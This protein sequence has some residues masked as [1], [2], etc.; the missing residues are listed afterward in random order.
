MNK[1]HRAMHPMY[2][3]IITKAA[4]AG[5]KEHYLMAWRITNYA[6]FIYSSFDFLF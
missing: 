6:F 3:V 2:N 1:V 4:F 5:T